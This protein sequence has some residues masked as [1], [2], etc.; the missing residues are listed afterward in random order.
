MK[1]LIGTLAFLAALASTQVTAANIQFVAKNTSAE[2]NLCLVAAQQG[3]QAAVKQLGSEKLAANTKCN[4]ETLKAFAHSFAAEKAAVAHKTVVLPG[5]QTMESQLCMKA[6]KEGVRA[7]GHRIS[8]LRC[9]GQSVTSFV[10]A[11]KRS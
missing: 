5:N 7:V 9:N 10:K 6:V 4:G 11:V 1:N 8:S 2:T 3:Y